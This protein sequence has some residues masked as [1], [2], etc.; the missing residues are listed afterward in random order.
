MVMIEKNN[1][2]IAAL[3]QKWITGHVR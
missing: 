1:L 3:L 2:Q